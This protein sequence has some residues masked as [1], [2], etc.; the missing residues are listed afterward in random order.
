MG[1]AAQRRANVEG[2]WRR[3]GLMHHMG[4]GDARG[5]CGTVP[6]FGGEQQR[7]RAKARNMLDK[8]GR[9]KRETTPACVQARRRAPVRRKKRG[10]WGARIAAVI[11]S[12]ELGRTLECVLQAPQT[13]QST[14][15]S[16]PRVLRGTLRCRGTRAAACLARLGASDN[17][18]LRRCT[19]VG[20][21]PA[22]HKGRRRH[23]RACAAQ[24]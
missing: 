24:A 16:T 21:W 1:A 17:C 15:A 7:R 19:R 6:A 4:C 23:E 13:F 18:R 9:E 8:A 14:A 3:H 2:S 20:L 22:G 11:A 10:A 12:S 5:V